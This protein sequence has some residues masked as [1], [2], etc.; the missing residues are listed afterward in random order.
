MLF[1]DVKNDLNFLREGINRIGRQKEAENIAK[2]NLLNYNNEKK[3]HFDEV[4]GQQESKITEF[5]QH[6]DK[7]D[8]YIDKVKTGREKN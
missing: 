1:S 6:I 5:Q 3:S 4:L 2:K 8:S 7:F